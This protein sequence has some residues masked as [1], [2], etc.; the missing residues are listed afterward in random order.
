M[1]A[2]IMAGGY[3]T[4][5]WPITKTR[6]KPL[7]PIGSKKIIDLI[8]EKVIDL[9]LSVVLSTN[10]RFEDDF[11]EW[12]RGKKVEVIAENTK[13][14]EEKLGAVKALAEIAK[15]IKDDLLVVAGDN[16]FSFSLKELYNKFVEKR[17]PFVALYDVGDLELAKRYGVAEMEGDKV[18]RF[19]EKPEKPPSSLIGIGVYFLPKKSVEILLEYVAGMKRSDN[20]GDFISFLCEREE[21]YGQKFNGIWYD[22]GNAD[23][24]IEAFKSYTDHYVDRS[25]EIERSA[26]IIEPV[27]VGRGAKITG[28]SI[29]GPYAFI[30]NQCRIESSDVSESIVF[31][32]TSLSNVKL[33]RS[34]VD[35]KCEIRNIQLV[36]SIIGGNA[37]IQGG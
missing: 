32:R 23:S 8:Y 6:A 31:E 14:E 7:L 4:R 18:I 37:K 20:L 30:G 19:Y 3:A 2:V 5:L 26:K 36:G 15:E 21:V 12:A 35:D 33:W 24:Y 13:S 16:V 10:K 29:I 27:V 28:R 17:R 22:V 1:R 11:R 25:A 34:I 9:E